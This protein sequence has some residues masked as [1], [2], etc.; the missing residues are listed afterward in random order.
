M[1][2][3]VPFLFANPEADRFQHSWPSCFTDIVALPHVST[4]IVCEPA[5]PWLTVQLKPRSS[6]TVNM[7][8]DVVANSPNWFERERMCKKSCSTQYNTFLCEHKPAPSQ[9]V[10]CADMPPTVSTT[11][12]IDPTNPP[13]PL[14]PNKE[15]PST[16]ADLLYTAHPS[17][18]T[19]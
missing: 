12:L 13:P 3:C 5:G 2:P 18:S 19:T 4:A 11:A 16:C 9:P 10:M 8:E 17:S 15:G 7:E 6:A 1:C 14:P